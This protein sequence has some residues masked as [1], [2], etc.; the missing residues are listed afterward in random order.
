MN[1]G[2]KKSLNKKEDVTMNFKEFLN[3]NAEK[4]SRLAEANTTR[5]SNGEVVLSKDDIWREPTE[6]EW[7]TI[8]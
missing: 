8:L 1:I 7:D 6:D 3:Q 2:D 5:N 4:V